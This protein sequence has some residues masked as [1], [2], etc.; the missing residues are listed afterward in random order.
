[1]T[2][3]MNKDV[4]T[5]VQI[6]QI[7][8]DCVPCWDEDTAM[9]LCTLSCNVRRNMLGEAVVGAVIKSPGTVSGAP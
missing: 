2:I 9:K 5:A 8:D 3:K 6:R 4:L 1:M 7:D